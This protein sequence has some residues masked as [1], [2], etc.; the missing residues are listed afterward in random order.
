ME[1]VVLQRFVTQLNVPILRKALQDV[2]G[3]LKLDEYGKAARVDDL[4]R[5]L[6]QA[7]SQGGAI[8]HWV[9]GVGMGGCVCTVPDTTMDS[10]ASALADVL[11]KSQLDALVRYGR[12]FLQEANLKE[13]EV[14]AIRLYTG[15][16]FM[17]VNAALRASSKMIPKWIFDHLM[18]NTY[19]FCALFFIG[20]M[21]LSAICVIQGNRKVY[22]EMSGFK[23]LLCFFQV[24]ER[25]V[26]GGVDFVSMSCTTNM[27]V[28][29]DYAKGG[30]G[31][32]IFV[33]D[34][35]MTDMGADVRFL[36]QYPTE[37]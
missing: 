24:D 27:S 7:L 9:D 23:F 8:G 1:M 14:I 6:D 22:R 21:K 2:P 28:A 5:R 26:R 16:L 34:E 12:K 33:I 18:G 30:M 29:I 20:I 10:V 25:G 11:D 15:P 36:S 32:L 19:M 13:E 3:K 4:C 31:T 37:G 17:K 35:G